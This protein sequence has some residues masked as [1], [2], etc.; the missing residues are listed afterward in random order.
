MLANDG[1]QTISANPT[2]VTSTRVDDIAMG[3]IAQNDCKNI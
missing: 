2:L 3:K 1:K